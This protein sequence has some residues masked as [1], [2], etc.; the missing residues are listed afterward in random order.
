MMFT[1]RPKSCAKETAD[2]SELREKPHYAT[3]V[4]N[5]D[6]D[7]NTRLIP[8]V[9]DYLSEIPICVNSLTSKQR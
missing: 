8:E 1:R 9:Y 7:P 6:E 2:T 3:S 5:S 4:Q